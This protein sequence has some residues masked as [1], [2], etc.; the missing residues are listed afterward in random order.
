LK[1]ERWGSPLFKRSTGEKRRVTGDN[2]IRIIITIIR[3]LAQPVVPNGG[4]MVN[5]Q[6]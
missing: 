3:A 2:E 1:P 6:I 5:I 4:L